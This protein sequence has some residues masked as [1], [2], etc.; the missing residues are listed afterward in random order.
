M[1]TSV[2]TIAK[3]QD[4]WTAKPRRKKVE[5]RAEV[6]IAEEMTLQEPGQAR[7]LTQVRMAKVLG[8]DRMVFP[9]W[10]AQRSFACYT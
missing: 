1:T 10:K 2:P 9:V 5:A 7:K 3:R 6:L 4:R 8:I